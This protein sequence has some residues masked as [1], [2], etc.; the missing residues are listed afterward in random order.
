MKKRNPKSELIILQ[1]WVEISWSGRNIP[2]YQNLG[3]IYTGK[4]DRF[5]C[6]INDLSHGSNVA[7]LVRCPECSLDRFVRYAGLI[8]AGHSVCPSCNGVVGV[9]RDLLGKTFGRL[10]VIEQDLR[11]SG[12]ST[13]WICVCECGNV[14]SVS[15]QSL[16]AG[17][18]VSCG[19]YHRD[20]VKALNGENSPHWNPCLTDEEREIGRNT[21]GN[22][23]WVN[24]VL[25]RDNYTCQCCGHYA[26]NLQ[27]HHLYSYKKYRKYRTELWNGVTLCIACHQNFHHFMGGPKVPCVADDFYR[28]AA[29]SGYFPTIA[30][31]ITMDYNW[32]ILVR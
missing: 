5:L 12:T 31:Y 24:D 17:R 32:L 14:C 10:L 30:S 22:R 19:C 18:T 29:Q 3:Y 23:K 15:S 28:F 2:Y 4:H 6:H 13:C 25:V 8:R 20:V 7:V 16:T 21:P 11:K 26:T 9:V 27:V 1:E